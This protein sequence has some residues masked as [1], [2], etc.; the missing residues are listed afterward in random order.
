MWMSVIIY[1]I[2][3]GNNNAQYQNVDVIVNIH[4]DNR[5]SRFLWNVRTLP[6][7]MQHN[8]EDPIFI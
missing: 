8:P 2:Y 5:Q 3:D 1:V 6:D 7:Y 4:N